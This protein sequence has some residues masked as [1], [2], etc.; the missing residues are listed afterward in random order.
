MIKLYG[1]ALSGN[2]HKVRMMLANE[3]IAALAWARVTVLMQQPR[4]RL[5]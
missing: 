4:D 3:E 5:G 1:S 2:C